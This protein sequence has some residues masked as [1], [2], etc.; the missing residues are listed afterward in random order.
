MV[1]IRQYT[2][3]EFIEY[4]KS[5]RNKGAVLKASFIHHT[6]SPTA[7]QYH[8]RPTI[9]GIR[10]SHLNRK[11]PMKD[12]ACH[13]YACPDATVFN[14]RPPTTNNCACQ[15]PD[16]YPSTWPAELR[17]ISGGNYSWMNAYGFGIE[18]IGNFDVEDPTKSVAMR[19]SLDVLA[20]VHEIWRIPIEHNF[21]H[22]DVSSK[23]CPGTRVTKE[24]V[25]EELRRRIEGGSVPPTELK[26]ILGTGPEPEVIDCNAGVENGV[27]RSDLRPVAEALGYEVIDH[28]ADQ[29]KIYLRKKQ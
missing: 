13:A 10:Q 20:A 24:W 29:N 2:V 5:Y 16:E 21:F 17:K 15:Y 6:W 19:T 27:T 28:I 23:T 26:V 14:G 12:I 11:P 1:D 4:L 18:T 9:L 8:G 7:A 3:T 25:H 22:R